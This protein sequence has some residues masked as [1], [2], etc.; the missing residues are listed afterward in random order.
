MAQSGNK[1]THNNAAWERI[2]CHKAG[3]KVHSDLRDIYCCV[4]R[5]YSWF[6]ISCTAFLQLDFI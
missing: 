4:V 2:K 5:L 6:F 3:N 1:S